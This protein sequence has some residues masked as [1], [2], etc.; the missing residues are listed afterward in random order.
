MK[1]ITELDDAAFL[2]QLNMLRKLIPDF[3]RKTKVLEIRKH[4]PALKGNETPEELEALKAAQI[5]QNISDMLDA[6]LEEYP[7]ET[8]KIMN[9]LV[10]RE[11]GEQVSTMKLIA[12]AAEVATSEDVVSFFISL[13]RSGLISQ[14]S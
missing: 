9:A 1:G 8:I 2:R 5:R 3:L 14:V 13:A 6:L 12:K 7:E 4:L 10:V 11:D